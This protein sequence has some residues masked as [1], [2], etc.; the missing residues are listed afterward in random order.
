MNKDCGINGCELEGGHDG[1]HALVSPFPPI[2][3]HKR[4]RGPVEIYPDNWPEPYKEG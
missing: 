3:E 2:P 1:L 4:I